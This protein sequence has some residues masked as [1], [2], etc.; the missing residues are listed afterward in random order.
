[1]S[2]EEAF[3]EAIRREPGD[4]TV[5]L[6]YADWLEE[7]DDVRG[8]FLRVESELRQMSACALSYPAVL[9]RW[10]QLREGMPADWVE[11]LDRRVHGLPL[12]PELVDLVAKR[13]WGSTKENLGFALEGPSSPW[14][15]DSYNYGLMWSETSNVCSR[16]QW[17]GKPDAEH[18]PGD[19][20]PKLTVMI[21]DQGL[22]SDV[23]FALDYR[24]SF[25]RPRVLLYRWQVSNHRNGN[26][27][28][29]N[30][31]VEV[32]PDFPAFWKRLRAGAT[33]E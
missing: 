24:V 25:R 18:A 26:H 17:L 15:V 6:V 1:M 7:R 20:D 27:L 14:E 16:L 23:P 13:R 22:G 28:D 33:I 2:D 30:R 32:A 4:E 29:G 10:L 12:P 11:A 19:I 21:A 8:E 3:L 9:T 31:W 5:R